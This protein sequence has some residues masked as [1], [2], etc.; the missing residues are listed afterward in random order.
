MY[1]QECDTGNCFFVIT[2][3]DDALLQKAKS[4]FSSEYQQQLHK[5]SLHYEKTLV[6]RYLVSSFFLEQTGV[7]DE[8]EQERYVADDDVASLQKKLHYAQRDLP[9]LFSWFSYSFTDEYVVVGFATSKIGIDA[10]IVKPRS[11]SLLVD[12]TTGK[13][14]PTWEAF[15]Q[16]RT[17]KE[18][19]VKYLNLSLNQVVNVDIAAYPIQNYLVSI[20]G[21]QCVVS[22]MV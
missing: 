2:K 14:Y 12:Q 10:E 8:I 22:V 18:A 3:I 1:K 16:S 17:A 4:A 5:T 9:Q 11:D 7:W 15:Y 19:L 21:K 6:A 20:D 13:N